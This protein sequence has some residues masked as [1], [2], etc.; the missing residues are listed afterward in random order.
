MK[1]PTMI[2]IYYTRKIFQKPYMHAFDS[3]R[4]PECLESTMNY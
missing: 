4:K 3:R 2:I 1:P